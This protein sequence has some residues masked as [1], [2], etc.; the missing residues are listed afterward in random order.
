MNT[1]AFVTYHPYPKPGEKSAS[2]YEKVAEIMKEIYNENPQYWPY[3]LNI[4]GH[5]GG[6][7]MIREAST[8]EP[9]G[10][11][12]WQERPRGMK[13]VGF[14]SIGVLPKFRGK[15][16]AKKAVQ[17]IISV[18]QAG[19]DEVRALICHTNKASLLLAEALNVPV[20]LVYS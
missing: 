11:V 9:I 16:L 20:E 1:S 15:G 6:V 18:K 5:D 12:G 8:K 14:Y 10:F 3:G 4:E 17:E 13:K 2:D 7:Y 19:V